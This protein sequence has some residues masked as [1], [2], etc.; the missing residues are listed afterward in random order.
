[1]KQ[2]LIKRGKAIA[3]E[4]P[5][6][7][8]ED[9]KVLVRV[10][11][12]CISIGTEMMGVRESSKSLLQK[13]KDKP[14]NVKKVINKLKS[15]GFKK[16]VN[17]VKSKVDK[18][19]PVG[20]SAAGVVLAVGRNIRDIKVGDRVA[21][22]GAQCAYHAEII[23][24]PRNLV[25]SIPEN[26]S[27]ADA[28]VVT[29]GSIAMQGVRRAAP[30]LGE[31]FVVI[32]LGVIGQLTVQFLKAN[33]CKVIVSDLDSERLEIA[34]KHGADYAIRPEQEVDVA[35]VEALT[36]GYGAD[37]VI[38]T[39]ASRSSAIVH[40]AFQMCR[41]KARVVCVG[42]VGLDIDRND[43]Y[44]KELDFL[45][46]T[47]YGPGRYDERYEE[48][49]LEYPIGYVRWT[50]NRNMQEV[51]SLM[52]EGRL[53]VADM[54]SEIYPVEQ[55]GEAYRSIE[56]AQPKPLMVLLSYPNEPKRENR[57][58][59]H[60]PAPHDGKVRVAI[61]GAGNFAKSM[62]L[63][64][65]QRLSDR[66]VIQAIMSRTGANAESIAREFSASYATTSYQE[67]LDDQEVDAVIITTRH[68]LHKEMV[69]QALQA[70]KHVLV[71][72]PLAMNES[73]L[74]EIEAYLQEH[75]DAP[76][77][78]TGYNRRHSRYMRE[79]ARH[80]SQR[81]NPMIINYR[82]NAG[83]IPLDVWVHTE[84]GGGRNIGEACHIYDVFDYLTG[85]EAESVSAHSISPATDYYSA[86]DNFVATISYSDGSVANL[87]Y[88]ALGNKEYP[89]ETMEIFYDNK[90]ITLNDYQSM[91][92][93][94]VKLADIHTNTSEKGQL[95]EIA[96]FA[97]AIREGHESPIPFAEQ[98][99]AMRIAFAVE[100][101]I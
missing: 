79:I 66:Y 31:C 75:P 49:G 3:T 10:V 28:S 96:A 52:A 43:I 97:D 40:T 11:N 64:N 17:L 69:L 29:L 46:S 50:E 26:V 33:G 65:L 92:G 61:I 14:E 2:V 90:M 34:M 45:I 93:Y 12:S 42:A 100:E 101:Q 95:E 1:M 53:Q 76:L 88:T 18:T 91:C 86:K 4:V 83:Y 24:V 55:A 62:H 81:I 5:E 25:V 72:K 77:L 73:E 9:D 89:K 85:A 36:G 44:Q 35:T 78:L 27:F 22:A 30:T 41:R 58:V 60:A 87:I 13:A 21:C 6:P 99:Q 68:N 74:E 15:D 84:E 38:I 19:A 67:V 80:T 56:T 70:G 23:N 32:G 54:V 63:P 7:Q 51:L 47:S 94:G 59:L 82:M 98:A 48:R 37:G 57:I 8:V 16:T 71:E 39:A 20:Y